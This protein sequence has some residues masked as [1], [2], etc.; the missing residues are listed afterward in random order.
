[1][2]ILLQVLFFISATVYLVM[3]IRALCCLRHAHRLPLTPTQNRPRVSVIFAARDEADRVE[4]TVRHLL[5]QQGVDL[6]IIAVDDRS[7]D[8]TAEIL[9]KLSQEDPRVRPKRVDLL[10][11]DWLG[12]CHACH[13]GASSATGEWLLFT[14]ADCWLKPDVLTRAIAVAERERV[15]H[16]TLTP[17]VSARTIPA[18]GWHIAFLITVADWIERTNRDHPRGYLGVGAFNL[19]RAD[20]YR[21]FGG[22]E[23]LRLT[24][25]DDVKLGKLVRKVGARTRAFIGGD[26]VECHWGVTVRHIIKIMEKNYFA[27]IDYRTAVGLFL[28]PVLTVLWA[29]CLIGPFTGTFLGFAAGL[30]LLSCIIPGLVLTQRLRWKSRAAF[31]TP[32]VFPALFYA[33]FRSTVITLK[34]GGIRWRDT[35]YP[36]DKLRAGNIY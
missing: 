29:F 35:F 19:V 16:I 32:F 26:D 17:G 14:D 18:E 25:V 4:N 8:Q 9:K 1:V 36:L 2:S 33:I 27:A 5:A 28:G 20:T 7:R 15:Q 34:Q 22:H 21:K 31:A 24:V 6:E 3:S 30:A 12:K 23:T 13:T 11:E 10:P